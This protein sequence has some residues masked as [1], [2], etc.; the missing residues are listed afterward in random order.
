[1]WNSVFLEHKTQHPACEGFLEWD[2]I[3][4]E[5][6]GMGWRECAIC[7]KCK[8]RS[9]MYSLYKEVT[10]RV[11]RRKTCQLNRGLAVGLSQTPI[12]TTSFRKI[13][14]SLNI[15]P[16]SV[17]GMQNTANEINEE[18]VAVNNQDMSELHKE[19]K[20]I[21]FYRGVEENSIDVERDCCYNNPLY[22]GVGKTPL[23]NI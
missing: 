20:N 11:G 13:C 10:T 18:L 16:P 9:R 17:R 2:M 1:M 8:Y 12:A 6:R 15:P 7:K 19:L 3:N 23:Q 5:Q 14:M 21:N 22:S 4:E